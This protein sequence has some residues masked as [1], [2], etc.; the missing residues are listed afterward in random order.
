MT[1]IY[2]GNDA[3]QMN[4]TVNGGVLLTYMNTHIQPPPTHTHTLT[5]LNITPT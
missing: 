1:Y 3:R 5:L 2:N 4:G